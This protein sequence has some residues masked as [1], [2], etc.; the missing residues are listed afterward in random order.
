MPRC[1]AAKAGPMKYVYLLESEIEPDRHYTGVTSDLK[2][3]FKEHNDGL[4]THTRKYKPWKLKTYIAF[5]N[6]EKADAFEAF[7][8]SGNGRMFMKKHF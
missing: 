4:S 6:E 1:S 5:S 2:R 7:L 3:R 8:K